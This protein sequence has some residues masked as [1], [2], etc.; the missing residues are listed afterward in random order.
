MYIS[1]IGLL[2]LFR[3]AKKKKRVTECVSYQNNKTSLKVKVSVTGT[4]EIVLICN[5]CSHC[6]F[7][8]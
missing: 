2:E 3:K 8:K 7:C 1:Q 5:I 6:N 4:G